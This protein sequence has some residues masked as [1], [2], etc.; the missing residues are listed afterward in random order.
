MDFGDRLKQA[1][2][3]AGLTQTALADKVGISRGQ[4]TNMERGIVASPQS[5]IIN[6][7]CKALNIN[8]DWLMTG[9]GPKKP[10]KPEKSSSEILNEIYARAQDLT[11]QEQLFLLDLV[12]SYKQRFGAKNDSDND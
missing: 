6:A 10:I 4:I 9:E 1:R 7:I 2:K 8:R 12:K 3:D 5:I 11:E